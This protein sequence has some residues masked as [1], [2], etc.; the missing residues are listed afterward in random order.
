MPVKKLYEEGAELFLDEND[1]QYLEMKA[2]NNC[3]RCLPHTQF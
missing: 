3:D 1:K 2:L